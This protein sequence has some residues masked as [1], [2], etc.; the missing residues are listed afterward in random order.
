[1]NTT[2]TGPC[3]VPQSGNPRTPHAAPRPLGEKAPHRP[4][5]PRRRWRTPTVDAEVDPLPATLN[6]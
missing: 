3:D 1:V 2:S 4:G 5:K 6:L